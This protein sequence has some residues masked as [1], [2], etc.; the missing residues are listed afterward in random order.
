MAQDKSSLNIYVADMVLPSVDILFIS[1]GEHVH[2]Y[3]RRFL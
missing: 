1:D 2:M 3:D